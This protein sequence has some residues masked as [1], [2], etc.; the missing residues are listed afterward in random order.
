MQTTPVL[1]QAAQRLG[2]RRRPAASQP[3]PARVP[4]SPAPLR[5]VSITITPLKSSLSALRSLRSRDAMKSTYS[6]LAATNQDEAVHGVPTDSTPPR[7]SLLAQHSSLDEA[8][9]AAVAEEEHKSGLN[10]PK[11]SFCVPETDWVR[12]CECEVC[13]AWLHDTAMQ[14]LLLLLL[15]CMCNACASF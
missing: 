12:G 5:D 4:S 11:Q 13:S 3:A 15:Q 7:K 10:R 8:V 1:S 14:R 2:L 9:A 6:S